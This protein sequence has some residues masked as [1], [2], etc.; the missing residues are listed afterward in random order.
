MNILR[1]PF[2]I[3]FAVLVGDC[4]GCRTQTPN[5]LAGWNFCFS[6][7]PA[8]L[9]KAIQNDYQNYIQNLP[10]EK[11]KYIGAINLFEDGKGRHAVSIEIFESKVNASWRY[12]LFYDKE[13]KR[14]NVVKYGY[15][16]YQS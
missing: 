13:N 9:D 8:K 3:L 6:Q 12:A 11:R 16:R 7:D 5:P 4:V 10:E 1:F 14:V 2:W 15:R